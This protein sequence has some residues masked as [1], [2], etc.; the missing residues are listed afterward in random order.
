MKNAAGCDSVVTV[1]VSAL[2]VS[3]STL[4][5]QVCPGA[6]YTYEGI[7]LAAGETRVF[8]LKNQSDCDSTVTVS[9]AAWPSLSFDLGSIK[10]CATVP[11]GSLAVLNAVGGTPPF[12][13]SLDGGAYQ[14]DPVFSALAPG[15]YTVQ[16]RDGHDCVFEASGDIAEYGA[17]ELALSDAVLACDQ[18]SVRLEP[19]VSGDLTG[20]AF[21]WSD[22]SR[23]AF[24]TA[25][26]AGKVWVE[27]SNICQKIRREAVVRWAESGDTSLVYIPNV[28]MPEG[29]LVENSVFRPFF[30]ANLTVLSYSL[31]VFDR[32]GNL[33]FRTEQSEA[34]WDGVFRARL[35]D[36]DVYPW[37]LQ[38]RVLY[39]G[40]EISIFQRGDVTVVR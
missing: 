3:A 20:L 17:L 2:P 31:D 11:N 25:S 14:N 10:S 19:A 13:Y 8:H 24:A 35:S 1:K 18:T 26:D 40:R 6:T 32:W 21:Q 7:S 12:R 27:A 15:A 37:L 33:V 30:A 4:N 28:F 36:G 34:D 5:V 22:G 9:V 23:E 16:V 29:G 38:A 39:C